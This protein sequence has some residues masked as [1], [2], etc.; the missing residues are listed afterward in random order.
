MEQFI[1][2]EL[3]KKSINVDEYLFAHNVITTRIK[4]L[5]DCK[6]HLIDD[7]ED[8]DHELEE[9]K[10]IKRVYFSKQS[11]KFYFSNMND[12]IWINCLKKYYKSLELENKT[13]Q[14][15]KDFIRYL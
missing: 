3:A 9:L 5:K 6:E 12:I 10:I 14:N 8:L 1:R 15:Y 2:E 13:L 4:I 11:Y 7:L